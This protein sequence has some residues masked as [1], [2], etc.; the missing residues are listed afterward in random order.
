M[1]NCAIG[2]VI[3]GQWVGGD[4]NTGNEIHLSSS[5]PFPT[6]GTVGAFLPGMPYPLSIANAPSPKVTA[7]IHALFL[8][9]SPCPAGE[10]GGAGP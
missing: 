8:A 9:P 2:N 5:W 4:G 1:R 10:D 7:L 6:E 3:L